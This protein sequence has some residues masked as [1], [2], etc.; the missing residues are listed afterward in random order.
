MDEIHSHLTAAEA[1][2]LDPHVVVG[3][4]EYGHDFLITL[5]APSQTSTIWVHLVVGDLALFIVEHRNG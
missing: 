5:L 2:K 3:N 1:T 4:H